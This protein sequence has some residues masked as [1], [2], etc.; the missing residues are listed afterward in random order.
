MPVLSFMLVSAY[1]CIKLTDTTFIHQNILIP[2]M[3]TEIA[4]RD[5]RS[6]NF[7]YPTRLRF[8]SIQLTTT[9]GKVNKRVYINGVSE[10]DFESLLQ[11]LRAH[12]VFV[13]VYNQGK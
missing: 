7:Y 9:D 3:R 11:Q 8:A 13:Q 5:I 12:H 1:T 4:Y 6:I 10:K 2:P